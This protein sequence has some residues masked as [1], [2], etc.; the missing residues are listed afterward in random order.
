MRRIEML[1][2][3]RVDL[4]VGKRGRVPRPHVGPDHTVDVAARI[5]TR[6]DLV[7]EVAVLGLVRHVDAAAAHVVLPAVIG[8]SESAL[9]VASDEAGRATM[10]TVARHQYD[11]HARDPE[12]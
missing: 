10:R 8:A 1:R 12:R 9:L 3:E 4:E 11:V 2:R 5:R 6:T 7:L